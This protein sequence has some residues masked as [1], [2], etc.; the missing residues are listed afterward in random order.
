M[1][2]TAPVLVVLD[3]VV[4][5]MR[6]KASGLKRSVSTAARFSSQRPDFTAAR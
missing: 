2:R 1:N 3:K 5:G 4:I 6:G